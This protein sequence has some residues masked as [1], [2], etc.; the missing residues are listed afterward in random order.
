M[1]EP[2]PIRVLL[3]GSNT[4]VQPLSKFVQFNIRHL[5]SHL[6]Y[7]ILDTKEFLQKIER[8]ND[9]LAPLPETATI[10]ICDVAKLYPSVN[11]SM[12]VP[13]VKKLL[14]QFPSPYTPLV[15]CVIEALQICLNC[16]ICK[17][18][19]GD[20]KTHLRMPNRG[21]AM[22]PCHACDYV[23]VFMGELDKKTVSSSPVP[24]ITSL[25][26]LNAREQNADL[27][28]SRFRDDGIIFLK[29][30]SHVEPFTKHLESLHPDIKWEVDAGK[31]MNYLNL[32]VKLEN[33]RIETDEYSKSSHNYL[34]PTS[35]HPPSTFKG[36]I[37][38]KGTQLRMNCS[39]GTDLSYRIDEYAHYFATCG[40]NY[41]Y[42][43]SQLSKGASFEKN[44]SQ[45][46]NSSKRTEI[47]QRPRK[48]PN[49][50]LAWVSTWDPRAPD[51]SKI[52]RDNLHLLYRNPA[53]REIFPPGLLI[54]ANRR[55]PNLGEYIK[56]TIPRRFVQHGP[57]LQPGSFPCKGADIEPCRKGACDL[58]KHVTSTYEFKSPWDERKW[59]IRDNLTC[60]SPNL[61]YLI[62]CK[63][64]DHE[65]Y[66]W[67]IGSAV[68]MPKRWR[69]HRSDFL[70][71]KV[72]KCRFAQ[73]SEEI[74]PET[75][76]YKPI[77]YLSVVFLE[78]VRD[79]TKL[80]TRESWWQ[81]NIGTIFFGLNK[82]KDTR[83][84]S[85]QKARVCLK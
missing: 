9:L 35:C 78:S 58:C 46:Q 11:N 69:N 25:L 45:D 39:K 29:D 19:T 80:L 18:T 55:R 21:T 53:N 37:S 52:I 48:K 28:W 6:P 24:L 47:L 84:V 20:G 8:I 79:E 72:S 70:N 60:S 4:P 44:D 81:Y 68:D 15:D 83:S 36:L 14:Q 41:D 73:H 10:T 57:N 27:D 22:G 77:E 5:P 23:D 38:S 42:A 34:P 13:A 51:K 16:N 76:K 43:K 40:W 2:W 74:H 49:K 61:I 31:K 33:G 64:S 1:P 59:R 75:P 26:P 63:C 7:Q 66:A 3:S 85:M 71:K 54:A 32:T 67:Y 50:K 82:R 62:I 17:F 30:D 65:K 56:P 12:G